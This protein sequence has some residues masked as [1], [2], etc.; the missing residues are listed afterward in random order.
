MLKL[1]Q[2]ASEQGLVNEPEPIAAPPIHETLSDLAQNN[3]GQQPPVPMAEEPIEGSLIPAAASLPASDSETHAMRPAS[4]RSSIPAAAPP[5]GQDQYATPALRPG[6]IVSIP[7]ASRAQREMRQESEYPHQGRRRSGIGHSV[8]QEESM[9]SRATSQSPWGGPSHLPPLLDAPE[10]DEEF[11]TS[12]PCKYLL[13]AA[14][15]CMPPVALSTTNALQLNR[16]RPRFNLRPLSLFARAGSGQGSHLEQSDEPPS[17]SATDNSG[18]SR[19]SNLEA[20]MQPFRSHDSDRQIRLEP[21]TNP[22]MPSLPPALPASQ[23]RFELPANPQDSE[24]EEEDILV[25]CSTHIQRRFKTFAAKLKRMPI[26]EERYLADVLDPPPTQKTNRLYSHLAT[27]AGDPMVATAT[28]PGDLSIPG[29]DGYLTGFTERGTLSVSQR[30]FTDDFVIYPAL[31]VHPETQ[32]Q[33]M[34]MGS[35]ANTKVYQIF[36]YDDLVRLFAHY[37]KGNMPAY[38]L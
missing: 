6:R 37:M 21:S 27:I 4:S 20:P 12:H 13:C 34:A 9:Q 22:Q 30:S 1:F 35:S 31:D 19:R 8:P 18:T 24:A 7:A 15:L 36:I 29:F 3:P 2:D 33:R 5:G 16:P 10:T 32:H 26:L 11:C 28:K 25:L 17:P 23:S 14:N 38:G